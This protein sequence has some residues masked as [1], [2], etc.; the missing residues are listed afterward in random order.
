MG[1][2][3]IENLLGCDNGRK[4][5]ITTNANTHDYTPENDDSNNRDGTR[6][7]GKSLSEGCED[8]DHELKA[9]H[10]LTANDIS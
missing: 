4:R 10:L 3:G 9:I 1:V 6:I 8:D 5:V 7:G 2:V